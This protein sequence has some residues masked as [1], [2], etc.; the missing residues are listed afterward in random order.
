LFSS[1]FYQ[2]F[3]SG[4]IASFSVMKLK[5]QEFVPDYFSPSLPY[6]CFTRRFLPSPHAMG[7]LLTAAAL[8]KRSTLLALNRKKK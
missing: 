8:E 6:P 3:G 7:L 2:A 5:K 4:S 1:D